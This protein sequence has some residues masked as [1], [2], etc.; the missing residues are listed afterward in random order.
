MFCVR[1]FS[2]RIKYI[3]YKDTTTKDRDTYKRKKDS[4]AHRKFWC[5]ICKKSRLRWVRR[6]AR[7]STESMGPN[8][9][10]QEATFYSFLFRAPLAPVYFFFLQTRILFRADD[11]KHRRRFRELQVL[12][13][14]RKS[15][16]THAASVKRR[17][18]GEKNWLHSKCFESTISWLIAWLSQFLRWSKK[19]H[20]L[21]RV[22]RGWVQIPL[23]TKPL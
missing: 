8:P 10:D 7:R 22:Y 1:I 17:E 3:S 15:L 16:L 6:T 19:T 14:I 4:C 9:L 21:P 12:I 2:L 11:E 23:C 20:I 5:S 13:R 18:H